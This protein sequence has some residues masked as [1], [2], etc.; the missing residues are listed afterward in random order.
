LLESIECIAQR[1]L[2][3]AGIGHPVEATSGFIGDIFVHVACQSSCCWI[4]IPRSR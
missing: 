3:G 4:V 2:C 1:L